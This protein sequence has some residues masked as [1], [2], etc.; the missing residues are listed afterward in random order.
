M[1]MDSTGKKKSQKKNVRRWVGVSVMAATRRPMWRG[2]PC[3]KCAG[4]NSCFF[5][6]SVLAIF[7]RF[8]RSNPRGVT[9]CSGLL[10]CRCRFVSSSPFAPCAGFAVWAPLI[11]E[12]IAP[13]VA[14]AFIFVTTIPPVLLLSSTHIR[15]RFFFCGSP[16]IYLFFSL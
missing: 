8:L 7:S 4:R 10:R 9:P 15:G 3:P 6:F 12:T 5:F 14:C 1:R 11:V 13:T 2:R 16:S